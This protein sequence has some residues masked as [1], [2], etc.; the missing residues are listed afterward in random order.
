M[1]LVWIGD[2]AVAVPGKEKTSAA[3]ATARSSSPPPE[4]AGG[5]DDDLT[6]AGPKHNALQQ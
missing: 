3:S 2:T 6:A 1:V 4:T 5:I